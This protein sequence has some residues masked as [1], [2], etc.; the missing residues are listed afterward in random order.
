M[1]ERVV[2]VAGPRRGKS[3]LARELRGK[4]YPT[5][6]GDPYSTVKEP[7]SG[8][9]YLP[10]GLPF[11]GDGGAADWI[12]RNWFTKPGPWVCEGHVM[13]RALRRWV[14]QHFDART[15]RVL[16]APCDR[17]IVL[18]R[19]GFNANPRQDGMHKGVMTA[20]QTIASYYDP[21]VDR[22]LSLLNG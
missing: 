12:A 15:G 4:G 6:C 7:E 17:I 18:N 16:R 2:I 22:K 13:A 20:W 9:F 8:V 21:I 5:F 1:K 11:S 10:E 14:K 19:A 3:T